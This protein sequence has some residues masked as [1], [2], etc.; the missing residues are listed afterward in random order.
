MGEWR[1]RQ[2]EIEVTN[3][4]HGGIS[5]GRHEGRVVFV[6]DAIPGERVLARISD[7]S[8]KSFWRAETVTVLAASE[9]RRAHVWA[10]ASIDRDP[11]D[12]AGGAEFG[13]IQ[14]AHQRELK[15]QVLVDS[16]QRMAGIDREVTVES[17]PGADDGTGWRTRVRLHVAAD[18]T[19]GPYAARSHH[20]VPVTT[21][22][23]AVQE[24]QTIAPLTEKFVGVDHID[25]VVPST[26]NPF[27]LQGSADRTERPKAQRIV[28]RV[29]ERDFRLD[30]R[31]FWQV[32]SAAAETLTTAVQGAID[33]SRFDPRA[34]NLDLY[35]G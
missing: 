33:E 4:A 24:A 9:H 28:E 35:G 29:G 5:V 30:A 3:I 10:E 16:L 20:V 21:L 7:D 32:H 8:K 19:V 2:V 27:V 14:T 17:L 11:D 6:S 15:R 34:A 25:V 22:P 31:G 26:G 18:G 13:H 23:L 12:R 1:G